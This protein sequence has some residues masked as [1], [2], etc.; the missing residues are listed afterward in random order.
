MC[1]LKTLLEFCTF[2]IF[3][4]FHWQILKPT[5]CA[6]PNFIVG[7]NSFLSLKYVY[8][9]LWMSNLNLVN[10]AFCFY[11]IEF[12]IPFHINN[13]ISGTKSCLIVLVYSNSRTLF[14]PVFFFFQLIRS[15]SRWIY[16]PRILFEICY[17]AKRKK[18]LRE[19]LAIDTVYRKDYHRRKTES[20]NSKIFE[21]LN[22]LNRAITSA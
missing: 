4:M 9:R 6:A 2:L 14:P 15:I 5:R 17:G 11:G 13:T 8:V 22:I 16:Q 10:I 1:I 3:S 7:L 20:N 12:L 21:N 19:Y 18:G